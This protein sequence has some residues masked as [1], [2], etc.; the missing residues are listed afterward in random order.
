MSGGVSLGLLKE[1]KFW[2]PVKAVSSFLES[3]P[4]AFSNA[5]KD[6]DLHESRWA[7][8]LVFMS[9]PIGNLI[10]WYGYYEL[11]L[12]KP[13]N[14]KYNNGLLCQREIIA[15]GIS[16]LGH[17]IRAWAKITLND[18]FTYTLSVLFLFCCC[19]LQKL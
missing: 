11:V 12:P 17:A 18:H 5:K 6:K 2:W 19:I 9:Q 7:R 13:G 8:Y 4:P 1:R 15:L 14:T 3:V 16:F 10:S